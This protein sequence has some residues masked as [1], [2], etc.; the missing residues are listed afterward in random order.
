MDN[1]INVTLRPRRSRGSS[2]G[3]LLAET[4]VFVG[5]ADGRYSA[6]W[7]VIAPQESAPCIVELPE[8]E[9]LVRITLDGRPALARPVD[10]RRTQVQLGPPN[11]PQ[12]LEVVTRGA[13]RSDSAARLIEIGRPALLQS[14]QRMPV[15]LSLWTL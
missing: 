7:F 2:A 15:E 12:S 4:A 3:V 14:D 9:Q 6:T 8:G 13:E 5:P 10:H 11:F 1:E